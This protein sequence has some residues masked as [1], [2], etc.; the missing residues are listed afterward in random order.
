MRL[1]RLLLLA[2]FLVA[3]LTSLRVEGSSYFLGEGETDYFLTMSRCRREAQS[4]YRDGGYRYAGYR[5]TR[6]F[7]W[8]T[9]DTEEFYSGKR[10]AAAI[11]GGGH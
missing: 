7:L 10:L 5:C 2:A 6:K 1:R 11:F 9:L 4:T 3:A 8:F